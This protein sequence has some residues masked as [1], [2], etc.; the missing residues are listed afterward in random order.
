MAELVDDEV[1]VERRALQENEMA[2]GVSA[3]EPEARDA[4]QPR[5]D[6][7]ADA[8][9]VHGLRIELEPV[10]T[11]LRALEQLAPLKARWPQVG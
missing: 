11:S 5:R 1:L 4:E 8:A 3:E 7:D 9:E 10:E 6:D 2:G